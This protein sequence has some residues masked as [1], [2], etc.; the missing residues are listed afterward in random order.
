MSRRGDDYEQPEDYGDA[1]PYQPPN[2]TQ[3]KA[4]PAQPPNSQQGAGSDQTPPPSP[5]TWNPQNVM[6]TLQKYQHTPQGLAQAVQENPWLGS[7]GGGK[8]DLLLGP[9]GEKIDVVQ[10]AGLG[11]TGWQ[12]LDTAQQQ[13]AGGAGAGAM[14]PGFG[15]GQ[16]A[17]QSQALIDLLMKRA[18][19]SLSMDPT[20]DSVIRPQVDNYAATQERSRRNYLND[21]AESSNPYATGAMN[22]AA[23]QTAETAGQN[24]ANLQSQLMG[25]E[26]TARRQEIQQALSEL[27]SLLTADQQMGLQ[28]E[29]AQIDAGLRQQQINSGNDQFLA[30][31]GLQATNNANF[32]DWQRSHGGQ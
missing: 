7:V 3:P 18:N 9:N 28:R 15:S 30:S 10:A 25:N 23:T 13:A 12:W 27:G 26:L 6:Q 16:A 8:G 31:L 29:L 4:K 5:P 2:G 1:D 11:G 14:G 19:Q 20:T 32:W 24:T 17:P 21:M 22:T